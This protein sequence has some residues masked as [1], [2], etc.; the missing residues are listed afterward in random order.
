MGA[1]VVTTST[2]VVAMLRRHY[3]P[4]GRPAS[5][6]F[7]PEIAS[8]CGKRRADLLW[9]PVTSNAGG[10][11]GHEVKVSRSDVLAELA[12]PTKADAW[13][14]YCERWWLVVSDPALVAGL[15]IPE[16]WGV[17][18]P[19][20]GRRTRS[21]TI[22]QAAPRL[23]PTDTTLAY[24]RVNSW[25]FHR[26]EDVINRDL[27]RLRGAEREIESLRKQLVTAEVNGGTNRSAHATRIA[28]IV[29]RVDVEAR[30]GWVW[31]TDDDLIVRTILDAALVAQQTD[32]AERTL[33]NIAREL[34][35]V[36][37]PIAP[38]ISNLEQARERLAPKQQAGAA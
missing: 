24:Q 8:P 23:K 9:A 32:D 20:S 5:G 28:G 10:L 26:Q 25:L 35:R 6:I 14:R 22:L 31:K 4:E 33:R 27:H 2:D 38:V 1:C 34:A 17:M 7:M 21:M 16:T 19:P 30:R 37:D 36:A 29:Q 3:L 15:D 13:M 11:V 18:A 12:D